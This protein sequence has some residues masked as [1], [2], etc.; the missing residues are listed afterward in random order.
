GNYWSDV[1]RGTVSGFASG[2]TVAAMRGGKIEM[3]Q[4][5]RDAFGNALGSSLAGSNISYSAKEQFADTLREMNR[6]S[7][8]AT[9]P[10]VPESSGPWGS[11]DEFAPTYPSRL[12]FEEGGPA[13][14]DA[15]D[16]QTVEIIGHRMTREE[17]LKSYGLDFF[18]YFSSEDYSKTSDAMLARRAGANM[19]VNYEISQRMALRGSFNGIQTP[20]RLTFGQAMRGSMIVGP[21]IGAVNSPF[22]I[23]MGIVRSLAQGEVA[24]YARQ[25]M[26]MSYR[27]ANRFADQAI[28][29]IPTGEVIPHNNP[30]ERVAGIAG[31]L[32]GPQGYAKAFTY[33]APVIKSAA[34][35]A[36]EDI[37]VNG[38]R[39]K[40]GNTTIFDTNWSRSYVVPP[41]SGGAN[42]IGVPAAKSTNP[43]SPVL[44]FDAHGNEIVYRTMSERHF[45]RLQQTDRLP[46]T[47]AT[48]ISPL[49]AFSQNYDGILVRLTTKPGTSAELQK[50]GIAE[51][52]PTALE[53]P[54]MSTRTGKWNTTNARFK[55]EGTGNP[56]INGGMGVMNTQLGKG[57]ALKIFNDNLL[58]YE[59]LPKGLK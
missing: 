8:Q 21:A 42:S 55:V 7:W 47:G 15:G 34:M 54:E 48:S 53:F 51:N 10:Q 38:F 40:I 2:V 16:M 3:A 23:S 39:L 43:L 33:A 46:G 19:S 22:T 36:A 20:N 50:I 56:V 57:T 59:Q 26:R 12:R 28:Q 13:A 44:E 29:K 31:E 1:A 5:A 52:T 24:K 6:G 35:Y 58:R 9:G 17:R 14:A 18:D 49:E 37:A 30:R 27:E 4:I 45:E 11:Y 25:E 32:F 41:G